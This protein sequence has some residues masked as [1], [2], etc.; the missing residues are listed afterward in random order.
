M[1]N[2]VTIAALAAAVVSVLGAA[3]VLVRQL[4]HQ[5]D[6]AAHGAAPAR[7]PAPKLADPWPPVPPR[8]CSTAAPGTGSDCRC[9]Y[10]CDNYWIRATSTSPSS[11]TTAPDVT[12]LTGGADPGKP[13][14][15]E[16]DA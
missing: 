16:H 13:P 15:V 8:A 6:P 14:G 2:P 4:Q 3:A 1:W 9:P 11:A 7:V 12:G 5:A 10:A